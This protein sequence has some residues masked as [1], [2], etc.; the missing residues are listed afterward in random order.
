MNDLMKQFCKVK[1]EYN[2]LRA[3]LREIEW[4]QPM[5]NSGP[6]CSWC[7]E[8]KHHGHAPDCRLNAVLGGEQ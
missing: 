4:V 3:L 1:R 6:S 8:M 2:D 7:G 5:S